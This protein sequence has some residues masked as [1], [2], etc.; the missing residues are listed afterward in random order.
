MRQHLPAGS[1]FSQDLFKTLT[2]ADGT[3]PV[4]AEVVKRAARTEPLM[5]STMVVDKSTALVSAITVTGTNTS[6]VHQ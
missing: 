4:N 3:N 1:E 6:N 5:A 2:V